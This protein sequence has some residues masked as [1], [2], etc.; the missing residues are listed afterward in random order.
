[1]RCRER[2]QQNQ[3]C[4]CHCHNHDENT[5]LLVHTGRVAEQQG[6]VIRPQ[7]THHEVH[8]NQENQHGEHATAG[9]GDERGQEWSVRKRSEESFSS[10]SFSSSSA[11]LASAARPPASAQR[12]GTWRSQNGP[13]PCTPPP[14]PSLPPP[15]GKPPRS[16]HRLFRQLQHRDI[17]GQNELIADATVLPNT[18]LRRGILQDS[19]PHPGGGAFCRRN[20]SCWSCSST[21]L[22]LALSGRCALWCR[23]S[24]RAIATAIR[25]CRNMER[26]RRSLRRRAL[27]VPPPASPRSAMG[28]PLRSKLRLPKKATQTCLNLA[29]WWWWCGCAAIHAC[30]SMR[31]RDMQ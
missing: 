8:R 19:R 24:A 16:V 25:S 13:T 2:N 26:R 30:L 10:S 15:Q 9:V 6:P 12:P 4:I 17:E 31:A 22:A 28:R 5:V 23:L 3:P 1:M 14:G 29:W 11:A 27:P 7:G 18:P 21:S 20:A